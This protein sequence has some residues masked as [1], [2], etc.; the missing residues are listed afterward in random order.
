[1]LAA[2]LSSGGAGAGLAAAQRVGAGN[3]CHRISARWG[4]SLAHN[5]R[6][7]L[8]NVDKLKQDRKTSIICTVGPSTWHREGIRSLIIGM[9]VLRLNFSHGSHEEKTRII[10]ACDP[11]LAKYDPTMRLA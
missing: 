7:S 6:L 3:F 4:N 2:M 5:M 10:A 1:M 8:Q 11:F 9:N